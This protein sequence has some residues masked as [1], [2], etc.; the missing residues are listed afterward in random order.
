MVHVAVEIPTL[1]TYNN[2]AL[3][4]VCWWCCKILLSYSSREIVRYS[5]KKLAARTGYGFSIFMGLLQ[6]KVRDSHIS[7]FRP[8]FE[9]MTR[10][11]AL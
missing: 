1:I 3:P 11:L 2:H 8:T 9:P 7:T 10:Q 6:L 5:S 4:E